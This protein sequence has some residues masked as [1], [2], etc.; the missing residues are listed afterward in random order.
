VGIPSGANAAADA[1]AP[2][3]KLQGCF[4]LQGPQGV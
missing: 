3:S 1:R 4:F 2:A